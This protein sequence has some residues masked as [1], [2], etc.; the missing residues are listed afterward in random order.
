[1][2]QAIFNPNTQDPNDECFTA[3]MKDAPSSSFDSLITIL[4][5]YV[6][7]CINDITTMVTSLGEAESCRQQKAVHTV[8]RG[9]SVCH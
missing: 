2:H 7:Q 8:S 4:V 6:G 1:M 3:G 9:P 5:P